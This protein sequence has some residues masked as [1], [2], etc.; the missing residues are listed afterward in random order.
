MATILIATIEGRRYGLRIED[1]AEV[2][3]SVARTPLPGAPESVEGIIDVRGT[4][5]PVVDVRARFGHA[6]CLQALSD[7][8]VIVQHAHRRIALRFD[9]TEEV[10]DVPDDEISEPVAFGPV[11]DGIAGVASLPDGLVLIHSMEAFLSDTEAVLL[12]DALSG[13]DGSAG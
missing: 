13:Q 11:L 9:A 3:W 5:V 12:E 10:V 6:P 2:V 1:V 7:R 4:V 8:L